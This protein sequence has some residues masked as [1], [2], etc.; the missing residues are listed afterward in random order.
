MSDKRVRDLQ[1]RARQGD[2]LA[3]AAYDAAVK[4]LGAFRVL[5]IDPDLHNLGWAVVEHDGLGFKVFAL[6]TV[7]ITAKVKGDTAVAM[8][9]TS[10]GEQPWHQTHG[11]VVE[12]QQAY[13]GAQRKATPED[14]IRLAQVAGGA[15][16]SARRPWHDLACVVLPRV[17]KGQVDKPITQARICARLG[18]DY[19]RKSNWVEPK[20]AG[21]EG[22]DVSGKR[23]SHV[24]DAIGLAIYG[25]DLVTGRQ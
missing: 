1:R 18:W 24:M 14:L 9:L 13:L 23:W 11:L 25:L 3:T 5:G 6:G 4:R 16:A 10:L 22:F 7:S 15:F 20:A 17:W 2:R 8:M 21:L 19:E 12:G